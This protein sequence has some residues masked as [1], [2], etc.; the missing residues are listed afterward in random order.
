MRPIERRGLQ[1]AKDL[2]RRELAVG[3]QS[4]G[5]DADMM[6]AIKWIAHQEKIDDNRR[7]PR[8]ATK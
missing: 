6:A 8:G 3:E 4:E 5:A 7:K 1:H 2:L